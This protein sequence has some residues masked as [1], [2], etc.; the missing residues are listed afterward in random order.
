MKCANPLPEDAPGA[1]AGGAGPIALNPVIIQPQLPVTRSLRRSLAG[2]GC[3]LLHG[4]PSPDE[5][6]EQ[7]GRVAPCVLIARVELIEAIEGDRLAEL[8]DYGRSVQVL[9]YGCP[10]DAQRRR[11]LLRRGC[12]G[13]L[14]EG[15][16]PA[17]VRKAISAAARGEMW[18]DRAGL[19][20]LVQELLSN[21]HKPK[22]TRRETEILALIAEGCNN[23]LIAERLSISLETVR[24][25]VRS[26]HAKL[27][28]KDRL[29]TAMYAR[30]MLKRSP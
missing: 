22:L 15:V 28:L 29:T 12:F 3:L 14:E 4:Q 13:F 11:V 8:T 27:H 5:L 20:S 18:V 2:D 6:I 21:E 1:S 17:T 23:R 24:W 30:A 19:T 26:L 25:H 9:V 7:C 10:H 16:S